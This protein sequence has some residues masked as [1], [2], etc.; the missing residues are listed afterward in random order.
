[1]TI[2][3]SLPPDPLRAYPFLLCI[4][5]LIAALHVTLELAISWPSEN[6]SSDEYM[7]VLPPSGLFRCVAMIQGMSSLLTPFQRD[8]G[9]VPRHRNAFL[10]AEDALNRRQALKQKIF[11]RRAFFSPFLAFSDAPGHISILLR[12]PQTPRVTQALSMLLPSSRRL[13][14]LLQAPKQQI[15]IRRAGSRPSTLIRPLTCPQAS[16]L[17]FECPSL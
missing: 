2:S 15:F 13:K 5:H 6:V 7:D 14:P 12:T 17:H 16:P 1:M 3:A 10:A 9:L 8:F 4:I 11:V